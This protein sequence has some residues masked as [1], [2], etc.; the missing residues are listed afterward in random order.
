MLS[1]QNSIL[2][3]YLLFIHLFI[4]FHELL[5]SYQHFSLSWSWR[6]LFNLF[7]S[8]F[9]IF[10][11]I[12]LHFFSYLMFIC[13]TDPY[14][15]LLNWIWII[16]LAFNYFFLLWLFSYLFLVLFSI[17][18]SMIFIFF[19]YILQFIVRR[20]QKVPRSNSTRRSVGLSKPTLLQGSR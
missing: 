15:S 19:A 14:L 4:S 16:T 6:L 7:N 20:N 3:I 11:S 12:Y 1:Y 10:L 2:C 18:I 8:I 13:F 9:F 5:F 17:C